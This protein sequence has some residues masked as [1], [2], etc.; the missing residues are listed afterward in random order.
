MKKP[1]NFLERAIAAVAPAVALRRAVAKESLHQFQYNA[2]RSTQKRE[3][4]PA[5]IAPNSFSVQRDR[6]QLMREAFDLENNF[7]PAKTL[8][9]KYAMFVAP[10]SYNAQTGLPWLDKMVE[11]YLNEVWFPNCDSTE[12][13]NFFRMLEFGVMGMNRGGDYG[14]AFVRNGAEEGMT[15]DE[16]VRLPLKIQGVEADRIGGVYQNVVSENYVSGVGIGDNGVPEYYRVFRRGMAAGQYTDPVDVPASQFVHYQDTMQVD[17]YRGVSKLDAACAELRDLYEIIDYMKGKSKLA[18]ALTVFTNSSGA[19]AGSGAMDAYA[20]QQMNNQQGGMQQDIYYGQV[21]HLAAGADIKF[22][23]AASPSAETQ[24]LMQLLLKL[25]CMTYNVPYSFGID[26]SALG[27]VSSRLE[28]EQARAE[29]ERGQAVLSPH[30]HKLK[31][32]AIFDA[33]AKGELPA[34]FEKQ[35]CRGR[36]GYRSHPQ[37]DIGR[38]ASAAVSLYQTGLL[39]PLKFWTENAQDPE[40]VASEM[41]RWHKIKADAV[42]GTG[43]AMQDVFGAGAAMPLAQSESSSESVSKVLPE[44]GGVAMQTEEEAREFAGDKTRAT[45]IRI[46]VEL[47]KAKLPTEQAIAAAYRIYDAG[48]TH[49]ELIKEVEEYLKE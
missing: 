22:P 42:E 47:L 28:S 33:V 41:V 46:L 48:K 14:W 11:D 18:S 30:A 12:R 45:T 32:A 21:N 34:G 36:F 1:P 17:M 40:T 38:E 16:L 15:V 4:A 31:D 26:A 7:A 29:F 39:N 43:Y 2:A 25:V 27:G 8:N 20:S 37:P 19:I 49:G 44:A 9:R 3:Q 10:Q 35:I 6:L 23:D 5:Q 13:Y 24:Y